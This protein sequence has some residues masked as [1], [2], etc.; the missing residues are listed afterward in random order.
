ML[1]H[2]LGSPEFAA[3]FVSDAELLVVQSIKPGPAGTVHES[4]G[5]EL[6]EV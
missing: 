3:F 2:S 6:S 4:V 5:Q 1:F